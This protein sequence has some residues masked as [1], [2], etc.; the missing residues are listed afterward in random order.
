MNA[1][2]LDKLVSLAKKVRLNSYSPY[3]KY[4]VGAALLCVS[5]QIYTGCNAEVAS[6]TGTEHAE[7][8]ALAQA[9]SAGEAN[10]NQAADG[11]KFIKM[12]VVVTQDGA[13]PCG[14][15][16]QRLA[17]HA[18]DFAIVVANTEGKILQQ[19]SLQKMLPIQFK[20]NK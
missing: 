7:T 12:V 17:E 1:T 20:L 10:N 11:Q 19:T 14:G 5:G 6:F 8:A 4:K 3:S 13:V 15:C 2:D 9:I 16:L 18:D